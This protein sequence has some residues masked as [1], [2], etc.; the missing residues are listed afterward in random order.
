MV[1]FDRASVCVWGASSGPTQKHIFIFFFFFI[2]HYP[3]LYIIW[4]VVFIT[5]ETVQIEETYL[6]SVSLFA[7][8]AA[9][10]EHSATV[11]ESGKSS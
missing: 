7:F 11:A 1:V 4:N 3:N 10:K 9:K 6:V 2:L 8:F 5:F